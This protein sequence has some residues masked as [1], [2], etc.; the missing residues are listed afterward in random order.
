QG[1]EETED[2]RQARLAEQE[3]EPRP[4]AGDGPRQ[5]Q[6]GARPQRARRPR[7]RAPSDLAR[8]GLAALLTRGRAALRRGAARR[9]DLTACR[10]LPP[11]A[12]LR[13]G[14]ATGCRTLRG[15]LPTRGRTLGGRLA[16]AAARAR[17]LLLPSGG[18]TPAGGT[19]RGLATAARGR[20]AHR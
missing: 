20:P 12:T 19:T 1:S 13:R 3:G 18:G 14:L 9:R 17:G 5:A 8:P 2:K 16:A 10:R 4:Q 6:L 15:R 7:R 11:R